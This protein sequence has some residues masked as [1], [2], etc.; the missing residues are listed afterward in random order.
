MFSLAQISRIL[1]VHV[2]ITEGTNCSRRAKTVALTLQ[3]ASGE[4]DPKHPDAN[5]IEEEA[6]AA[7]LT[8]LRNTGR[9][10]KH[11]TSQCTG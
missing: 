9:C 3:D 8:A 1:A 11:A 10:G 4:Q 2:R 6:A 5:S 7:H